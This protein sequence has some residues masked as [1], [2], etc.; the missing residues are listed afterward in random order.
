[1]KWV[2]LDSLLII[3]RIIDFL[4][5]KGRLFMKFIEILVYIFLGIGK[6]CRRFGDV[7][8]LYLYVW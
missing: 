6:G 2:V 1:M 4:K 8:L 3:I 7:A 5:D